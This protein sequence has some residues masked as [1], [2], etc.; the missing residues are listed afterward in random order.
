[1]I[2]S[3]IRMFCVALLFVSF[4]V[5]SVLASNNNL[6]FS[7]YSLEQGLS[8]ATVT[9]M[10]QDY[11]GFLWIC[12]QDGLNRFDG[13][14]FKVFSFDSENQH[15][16]TS[17]YIE[18][19]YEDENGVLWIGTS[20]GL[21]RFD[22]QK[23]RFEN[24]EL[25]RERRDY[26]GSQFIRIIYPADKNKLWIGTH[27][28][29]FLFD[30]TDH[31]T[32]L[33]LPDSNSPGSSSTNSIQAILADQQGRLWV[34]AEA[35][36]M[37]FDTTKGSFSRFEYENLGKSFTF[38][39]SVTSIVQ[40]P[41]GGIWI[42]TYNS[43]LY[44]LNPVTNAV[45]NFRADNRNS[46]SLSH[47]RVRALHISQSGELWI[48]TRGGVSLYDSTNES[49]LRYQHN[50]T[51]KYSLSNDSVWSISEDNSGGIWFGTGDGA[52]R[53]NMETRQFGHQSQSYSINPRIT[54]LNGVNQNKTNSTIV[55]SSISGLNSISHKRIRS[56]F[57]TR[58]NVLWVGVDNGLNRFDPATEKYTHYFHESENSSSISRGMVMSILVDSQGQIWAG[59]YDG[60]VNLY[61]EE[62]KAFKHYQH[63]KSDPNSLSSNRIYSIKEDFQGKLWI[64]T[65]D[66]LN[67]F[68]PE[69]ETFEIF[70]NKPNDPHSISDNG[71]YSTLQGKSGDIWVAT[72]NGGLNRLNLKTGKFQRFSHDPNNKKTVSHSRIFAL[73]QD[74]TGVLWLGTKNGLDKHVPGSGVFTSY[75]KKHG[76]ANETVY[77]VAGDSEGF[78]WVSTNH[79]LARFDPKRESFDVYGESRGAQSN[80][81]NNGAFFKAE[82]GELFFGG[83]NGFNRFYPETIKNNVF[84]P[85]LAITQ[86]LLFNRPTRPAIGNNDSPLV[87]AMTETRSVTLDYKDYVF[88]L[89]LSAIHFNSP[90]QNRYLYQLE[91]FDRGWIETDAKNRRATYTNLPSGSY[92]F[93]FKASNADG[94]WS[95]H[96]KDIELH[97]QPA[98]WRTWW[99]YSLYVI[100]FS[101]ILG[102]FI[103]VKL[104]QLAVERRTARAI[105]LSQK[106]L[107]TALWGSRSEMWEWNMKIGNVERENLLPDIIKLTGPAKSPSD[108]VELIH[109]DDRTSFVCALEEHLQ[110]KSD[111]LETSYRLKTKTEDWRWILDR[112]QIVERDHNG[113]PV[114]MCGILVD[115]S[116]LK[117]SELSRV[118]SIRKLVTGVA[119][120]INT[121]LGI[122]ITAISLVNDE[123]KNIYESPELNAK[124]LTGDQ[125][126]E[127]VGDGGRLVA[128]NL[129]KIS[130]LITEF[131][132]VAEF[133]GTRVYAFNL[134]EVLQDCK[135]QVSCYELPL[136]LDIQI[137]C[138]NKILV[139]GEPLIVKQVLE[140]LFDNSIEHGFQ[141]RSSGTV[142]IDAQTQQGK[143][144]VTFSDSGCGMQTHELEQAFEPFFTTKRIDRHMGLGLHTAYALVVNELQ[145]AITITDNNNGDGVSVIIELKSA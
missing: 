122:S 84:P 30:T 45:Q 56:L 59:T 62:K 38:D 29:L 138:S 27:N 82:D 118:Q 94:V 48:G 57:K 139:L 15:S 68:D 1:M 129:I 37:L 7:R 80:E 88:A 109:E 25:S 124:G 39:K 64:G 128:R 31:T 41:Q 114:V 13:Y 79:G 143:V 105:A 78:I 44:R 42:G 4:I 83:I 93:R 115:I 67:R 71:I 85:K 75:N 125:L 101:L 10:L 33:Y 24:F 20:K 95:L 14:T 47:D 97:V 91:G 54:E 130:Q 144:I 53:V 116:Q 23:E 140:I 50:P 43:G 8:Q 12:T 16:L 66:G 90:F 120:E 52:N 112:G 133:S 70:R 121:P 51:Q 136:E 117:A 19:L 73:Y 103:R 46:R 11:Q 58:S 18:A 22:R 2:K 142:S 126:E 74:D 72:R 26:V 61:S 77:A 69:L 102:S 81:F 6:R 34:G 145:G 40:H 21:N 137:N 106:R 134:A 135:E 86:L 28:G 108:F 98:P 104:Q 49:F 76:L 113:N 99:A 60:G 87:N 5:E 100:I 36:L 131:K 141:N 35:G 132:K 89:E 111:F 96:S 17:S 32:Q 107:S 3:L 55:N 92:T 9:C 127:S 110:G 65:V 63:I 119:H 123:V